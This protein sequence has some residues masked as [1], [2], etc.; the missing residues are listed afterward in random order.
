MLAQ[1]GN[2]PVHEAMHAELSYDGTHL[3]SLS[4]YTLILYYDS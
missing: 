3:T 1:K 2:R 4:I